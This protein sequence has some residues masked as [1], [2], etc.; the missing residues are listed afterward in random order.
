MPA[1]KEFNRGEALSKG[2]AIVP[3]NSLLFFADVD[4][5]IRKDALDRIRLNTIWNKQ[6]K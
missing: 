1:Q 3:Q 2:A 4:V 6:V 5:L